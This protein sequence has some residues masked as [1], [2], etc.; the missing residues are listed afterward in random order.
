MS[1]MVHA[2]TCGARVPAV[3]GLIRLARFAKKHIETHTYHATTSSSHISFL[4]HS[5]CLSVHAPTSV[6]LVSKSTIDLHGPESESMVEFPCTT[7]KN[8]TIDLRLRMTEAM[9]EFP[10]TTSKNSTIDLHD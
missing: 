4:S 2:R 1:S 5:L 7:S 3:L 6:L 9:V 8:S 10:C